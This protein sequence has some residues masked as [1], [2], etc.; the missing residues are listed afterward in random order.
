[1]FI[2]DIIDSL[3]GMG[4]IYPPRSNTFLSMYELRMLAS[5]SNQLDKG[6]SLSEKQA[7]VT[8]NILSK[9]VGQLSVYF[10]RDMKDSITSPKYKLGKRSTNSVLKTIKLI[11][12]VNGVK[13]IA[14][15][16]PYDEK[17]IIKI[18][19]LKSTARSNINWNMDIRSWV[20]ELHE[21]YVSWLYKNL[22]EENF[23]FD[24]EILEW[25]EDIQKI[26]ENID[27]YVSIVVFDN[28]KF[29]I[30]NAHASVPQPSGSDLLEILFEAKKYGVTTW[31]ENIDQALEDPMFN[32]FTR[33]FLKNQE[34]ISTAA[35]TEILGNQI[36]FSHLSDIIKYNG[37]VMIVI[38]GGNEFNSLKTVHTELKNL[39]YTDQEMSVLF[40]TEGFQ[41]SGANYYIKENYLNN[42]ISEK[43]KIY[44]VSQKFPKPLIKNNV[45]IGTVINLGTPNVHH[46]LRNF[47]KNHHNV[48][49]YIFKKEK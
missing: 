35:Q 26:E 49:L 42:P 5:F 17:L 46:S 3:V 14:V 40:R 23:N 19:E 20:F 43:I 7:T 27:Q 41:E 16:F 12:D 21:E 33:E 39:G 1:M 24:K 30:N 32:S 28:G 9:Y 31:D 15:S 38:P 47:I 25:I 45:K 18:K 48:L 6:S 4:S 13:K 10:Q 44:F 29:K 36:P 8:E 37:T 22:K 2:E 34:K 11:S